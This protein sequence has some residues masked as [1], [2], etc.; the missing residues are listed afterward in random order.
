MQHLT[1]FLLFVI[2]MCLLLTAGWF[3]FQYR[4]TREVMTPEELQ[5]ACPSG[6]EV[7]QCIA[8]PCCCKIGV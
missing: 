2:C 7:Q 6:E 5:T 3:A 8:G 1:T 4:N